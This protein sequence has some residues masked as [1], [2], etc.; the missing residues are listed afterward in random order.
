MSNL[1]KREENGAKGEIRTQEILID[2]FWV[3]KRSVDVEGADLLVQIPADSLDEL[4]GRKSKIQVFGVIQA[5]YFEGSNQVKILKKY[6]EDSSGF[7]RTDFFAMLH[8]NDEDGENIQYFF[9][10]NE[11]QKEFYEDQKD[12][13]YCFS[14]TKDRNYADFKNKKKKHIGAVIKEGILKTEQERNK[15]LIEIIYVNTQQPSINTYKTSPTTKIIETNDK[16]HKLE[17]K[18]N[19]IEITKT[20]K[21]TG[22]KIVVGSALGNIENTD[23]DPFSGVTIAKD[24]I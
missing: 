19:I 7:P 20:C 14:L 12:E 8:S 15:E 2:Y 18:G 3:L 21:A 5:K 22:T 10:A 23:Y 16:I 24:W 11:V 4:W 17:Q 13:Y 9:T 1:A 6:V